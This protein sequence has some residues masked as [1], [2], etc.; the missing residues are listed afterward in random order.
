MAA[1]IGTT[2]LVATSCGAS[3]SIAVFSFKNIFR[4][5]TDCRRNKRTSAAALKFELNALQ[6]LCDLQSEL[7][8]G[9]YAP[10]GAEFFY[11]C[12]PK[13]REIFAPSFR[14]RVV[15]YLFINVLKD[16]YE[17][18]IN[19][20]TYNN[21][22]ERGTHKAML[23]AREYMGGSE[24]YLQLDI[25]NFFYY[26]DKDKL[27][28]IFKNDLQDMDI[29]DKDKLLWLAKTIIY[30]EPTNGCKIMGGG[31]KSMSLATHKS[32]FT[33][34]KNKGLPIGNLTSQFFA[35]VYMRKFDEFVQNEL[36]VKEYIRHV[37]DFVLF[38]DSKS[39][40][41]K[42]LWRIKEY[43]RQNLALDLRQ[44]IRLRANRLGLDF[45]GYIVRDRYVL[46]R[47]RVVKNY[48]FKKASYLNKYE[49]RKE[50]WIKKR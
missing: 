17:S 14:D 24:F 38:H 26:V 13:L 44:D 33:L 41:Q 6:E 28:E 34:P 9:T 21:V 36:G 45:L 42:C 27:F 15:H 20:A 2:F 10:S 18:V 46:V 3:G 49:K 5:Y 32:L 16:S 11:S 35:N 23:K 43:L 29:A 22:K 25:K 30:A 48:K 7:E 37:D 47:N 50:K 39:Y 4:A 31:G 19:G 40:L 1:T 12:S 8:N